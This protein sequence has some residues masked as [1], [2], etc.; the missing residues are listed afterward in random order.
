VNLQADET[1]WQEERLVSK[2]AENLPQLP[3][4]R[5]ISP[6]PKEVI[7]I[8]SFVYHKYL[9]N[10]FNCL[11]TYCFVSQWRCDETGVS[12]N[13]WLNLSTGFIGSGRPVSFLSDLK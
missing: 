3:C 5:N 12:D 11:L 7:Q 4:T 10:I 8:T 9:E 6:N 1:A 2:Y 13:L